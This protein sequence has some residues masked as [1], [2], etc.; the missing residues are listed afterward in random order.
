MAKRFSEIAEV[1][2][3]LFPCCRPSQALRI[4]PVLRA[5]FE[6][7]NVESFSSVDG[8]RQDVCVLAHLFMLSSE[9]V[10]ER[11]AGYDHLRACMHSVPALP[12]WLRQRPALQPDL[13]KR[14]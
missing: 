8:E 6:S 9:N 12:Q 4:G 5:R 14:I 3:K 11:A 13:G 2:Q 7:H 1:V 10:S